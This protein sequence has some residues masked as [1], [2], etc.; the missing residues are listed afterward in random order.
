V[1]SMSDE[2][3]LRLF[4]EA[5]RPRHLWWGDNVNCPLFPHLSVMGIPDVRR[6][7]SIEASITIVVLWSN[8][9]RSR[10]TTK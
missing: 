5:G 10:F 9:K 8:K 6:E 7:R 2:A 4:E 1:T 3:A